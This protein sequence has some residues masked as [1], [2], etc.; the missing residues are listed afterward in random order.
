[1]PDWT[2][3]VGEPGSYLRSEYEKTNIFNAR[4]FALA[5]PLGGSL[6]ENGSEPYWWYD[7]VAGADSLETF[8]HIST[9]PRT[10]AVMTPANAPYISSTSRPLAMLFGRTPGPGWAAEKA[11]DFLSVEPGI[12]PIYASSVDLSDFRLHMGF[13]PLQPVSTYSDYEHV[14]YVL[15]RAPN[16][17]V[18]RVPRKNKRRP[19]RKTMLR[20]ARTYLKWGVNMTERRSADE[21]LTIHA[22]NAGGNWTGHIPREV[23]ASSWFRIVERDG[24]TVLLWLYS[25]GCEACNSE[26]SVFEKAC[27]L[28]TAD[29]RSVFCAR[30]DIGLNDPPP[31]L[32]RPD[33]ASALYVFAPG[34]L[35]TLYSGVLASPNLASFT[36]TA[37]MPAHLRPESHIPTHRAAVLY[38]TVFALSLHFLGSVAIVIGVVMI[39]SGFRAHGRSRELRWRSQGTNFE[40]LSSQ[41]PLS[42]RDLN[43]PL[44]CL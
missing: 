10:R 21:S 42:P 15:F 38:R 20:L 23:S 7:G 22:G 8:M 36:R 29:A 39:L 35:P 41:T 40:Q 25:D 11:L 14:D 33:E 30:M 2:F 43:I 18:E 6:C 34:E 31:Y 32:A 9:I 16:A 44:K 28:L 26:R 1:V 13:S 27:E 3:L 5:T 24:R 17:G 37:A 4:P 19:A 12:L